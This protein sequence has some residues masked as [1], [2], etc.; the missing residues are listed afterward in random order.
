[1]TSEAQVT[2]SMSDVV[3]GYDG[4][5]NAAAAVDWAAREAA[6][7]GAHLRVLT[8]AHYPGMPSAVAI[9]APMVPRSLKS[10]SDERAAEGLQLAAKHLPHA[11]IDASVIVAGAA[12]ALVDGSADAALVVVG[13]RGHGA[14]ASAML[15]SVSS[16]VAE[17]AV[18]PVVVVRGRSEAA[19]DA[20][21]PVTVG[22]DGTPES[23]P[24][25]S[26][27]AETAARR[28][29]RLRVLCAWAVRPPLGWE[30]ATWRPEIMSRWADELSA[31]AHAS[32][33]QAAERVR[34]RW[35]ELVVESEAPEMPPRIALEDASRL[36]GLLVV[37]S[38]GMGALGRILMGSVSRS[39]LYH[40]A[41]PVAVVK[42]QVR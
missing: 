22:V 35:P 16:A 29:V 2:R 26:M 13:H 4:S 23:E 28:A 12:A 25:L 40:A 31:S 39:A 5:R 1:M 10:I 14:F 15:G 9:T 27:A 7:R 11:D 21:R 33:D 41:C 38:G 42:P 17:H 34:Q 24:A 19:M 20:S 8:A 6:R 3:V 18:C 37:G 30:Y 36:S 32:A